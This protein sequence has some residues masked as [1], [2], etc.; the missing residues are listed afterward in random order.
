MLNW[1]VPTTPQRLSQ[2]ATYSSVPRAALI[3]PRSTMCSAGH[4]NSRST[5]G[6]LRLCVA[7]LAAD[8]DVMLAG[9]LRRVDH[10]VAVHR[11]QSLDDLHVG[12]R[13]LDLLSERVL[14]AD[15][16]GRR[17]AS[18]EVEHV[19]DVDQD[20]SCEVRGSCLPQRGDRVLACGAVE[21][22]LPEC[23]RVGEGAPA[24]LRAGFVRPLRAPSRCPPRASPS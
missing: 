3:P 1:P 23:R 17:P 24:R 21:H 15:A 14:C 7:V 6:N 8:E 12:K 19:R 20:L 10:D 9:N 13:T 11:I 4:P 16:N 2:S 18:G 5:S 22:E